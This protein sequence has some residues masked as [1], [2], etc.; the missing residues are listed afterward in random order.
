MV[1]MRWALAAFASLVGTPAQAAWLRAETRHFIV[2]DNAR[3]AEVRAL[4]SELE[5]FDGFVRLFH[6]APEVAGA[7]SNKLTVYVVPDVA[8]VQKL[9]GKCPNVY[10]FYEGRVS[11]SVAFTPRSTPGSDA[12][13]LGARTVLFHEYGHHFLL[14]AFLLA[15]PAWFSEGYA[16]FVSTMKIADKVTIGAAAQHRAYGLLVAPRLPATVLFDPQSRKKLNAMEVDTLYGRGW[17]LTHWIMFD[18][19]RRDKFHR[20][21]TALNSGT[22]S[23]KAATDAFGDLKALDREL[24]RYLKQSRIPAAILE[25]SRVPEPVVTVTSLSPGAQDLIPLR[26]VSTR[27]V[28]RDTALSLYRKAAPLAARHAGDAVAQGWFAEIAADAGETDAATQA[29]ARALATDPKSPQALTYAAI[30]AMR[31]A[32]K[33]KA[34]A[35]WDAARKAIIR[36]NRA[37]PDRAQ[38]LVLFYSTFEAQGTPPRKSAIDG[39]YRAQELVPQDSGVRALAARQLIRDKAL[40][41]ARRMLAP[42]AFDPHAPADNPGTRA[43]ARLDAGDGPGALAILSGEDKTAGQ[44]AKGKSDD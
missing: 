1:G 24:D 21:L 25:R 8:A 42:L 5:R 23:L 22:P 30:L 17:L 40:P 34:A 3:E 4:A 32:A 10:G 39:L 19:D 41:A 2:Y 43:I 14:G 6:S 12:N 44:D 15:Y 28:D 36:A 35:D 38:P 26:L 13:G 11:G 16:E 18:Q 27:G 20:Y 9:C 7:E 31:V 33:S 37:D 29:V